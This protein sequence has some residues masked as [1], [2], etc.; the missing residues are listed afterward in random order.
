MD[1]C[2]IVWFR[3]QFTPEEK[4]RRD[5]DCLEGCTHAVHEAINVPA[6]ARIGIAPF[7]GRGGEVHQTL[8]L[9]RSQGPTVRPST[10]ALE[11]LASCGRFSARLG[12]NKEDS[13]MRLRWHTRIDTERT[14]D[15]EGL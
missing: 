11:D 2:R 7:P 14:F 13:T 4:M 8:Q 1:G 10:E 9:F 15:F 3:L 5:K 6:T 12:P